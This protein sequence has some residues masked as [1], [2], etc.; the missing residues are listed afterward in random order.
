MTSH[1]SRCQS[2]IQKS[3]EIVCA[4][5]L[6]KVYFLF[7]DALIKPQ[8]VAAFSAEIKILMQSELMNPQ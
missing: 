2:A 3:N 5:M 4:Q 7:G 1:I 8:S 6:N